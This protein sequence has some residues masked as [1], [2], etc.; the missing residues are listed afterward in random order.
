VASSYQIRGLTSPDLPQ[1]MSLVWAVFSEFEAPEYSAEGIAEFKSFIEIHRMAEKLVSGEI[2]FWGCIIGGEIVGVIATRPPC[3]IALLFVRRDLHRQGIARSLYETVRDY[4]LSSGEQ[5][6]M[7]VNSSPY[8]VG[9]YA[10]LGFVAIDS[11]QV[12]NGLRFTPMKN[13]FREELAKQRFV[14]V[15]EGLVCLNPEEDK[16]PLEERKKEVEEKIRAPYYEKALKDR[17]R[18]TNK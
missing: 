10:R 18:S 17:K 6:T 13:K 12:V 8:A 11:E 7:T 3:H 4:Y 9:A 16:R 2:K 14:C 1:A 15:P 5:W